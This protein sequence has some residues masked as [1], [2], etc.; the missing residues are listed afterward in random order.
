MEPCLTG[1]QHFGKERLLWKK[2]NDNWDGN[3]GM[4]LN[5]SPKTEFAGESVL[6]TRLGFKCKCI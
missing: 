1:S 2:E 3:V 6:Q 5:S 4:T